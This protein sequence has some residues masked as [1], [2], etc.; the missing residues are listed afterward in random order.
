MCIYSLNPKN[1]TLKAGGFLINKENAC[2]A[3]VYRENKDDYSFPKGHLEEGESLK[4]CAIR[5][6][7]EETKRECKIVETEAP[8]I[9]KYV[10]PSGENCICYFY[11]AIDNGISDNQSEDTHETVWV[12]IEEVEDKVSYESLKSMWREVKDKVEKIIKE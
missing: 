8:Y 9:Q 11:F 7:A 3:L 4:E 6:I 1:E 10:T 12:H 2:I 5:E